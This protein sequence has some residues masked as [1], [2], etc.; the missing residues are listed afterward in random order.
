MEN[1]KTNYY[2]EYYKKNSERIKLNA[3]KWREKNKEYL[4]ERQRIWRKKNPGYSAR[5]LKEYRKNNKEKCEISRNKSIAKYRKE[6]PDI[7]IT[8]RLFFGSRTR[9]KIK[10]IDFDLTQEWILEK[11]RN[12]ICPVTGI[13]FY[14]DASPS[15]HGGAQFPFAPSLD[16]IDSNKGYTK[17]NTQVVVWIYNAAKSSFTHNDVLTLAKSIVSREQLFQPI[18]PEK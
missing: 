9:S 11:I 1:K 7:F 10:K 5:W 16:R 6:S 2:E 13:T 12:G 18:S 3:Q 4:N 17:E 15:K 14:I 8:R